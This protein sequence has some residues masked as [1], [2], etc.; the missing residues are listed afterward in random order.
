MKH[1][2]KKMCIFTLL[3]AALMMAPAAVATAQ[4][5]VN[6][7]T[8]TVTLSEKELKAQQKKE[9]KEAKAK[10]KQEEKEAKA[11]AKKNKPPYDWYTEH[12]PAKLSGTM[13]ELDAYIL[14]CDTTFNSIQNYKENITFFHVDT[15]YTILEDG[16]KAKV[17][18][19]LDQEGNPK[20]FSKSFQQGAEMTLS[21]TNIILDVANITLMTAS[22]TLDL[23][24]D[25][26]GAFSYAKSLKGGPKIIELAYVEVKEIVN[27][28][29]TQMAD[30]K[31]MKESKL[32]GSTD[33]AY[34][35]PLDADEMPN[36]EDFKSITE[37]DLG[38]S[39]NEIDWSEFENINLDPVQTKS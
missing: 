14:Y 23:A 3:L 28:T 26:I 33:Q 21:G 8:E 37:I 16:T 11:K 32:E 29:K 4:D 5:V 34:I 10:A 22:A 24:S 9:E 6:S 27:A 2:T 20:N 39:D 25:P 1:T 18:K 38:S 17:V 30:L 19:I 15:V 36:E 31:R 35:L 12:R 13:K 7:A